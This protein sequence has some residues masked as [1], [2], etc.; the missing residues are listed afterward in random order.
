[1]NTQMTYTRADGYKFQYNGSLTVNVYDKH[2]SNIDCF[3][4]GY[5]A[6]QYSMRQITDTMDD[7]GAEECEVCGYPLIQDEEA[8]GMGFYEEGPFCG[9]CEEG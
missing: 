6:E 5:P 8:K 7:W 2:G 3:T 1:M 9:N 4:L